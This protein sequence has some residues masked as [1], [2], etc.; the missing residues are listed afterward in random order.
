MLSYRKRGTNGLA[1]TG[2][3]RSDWWRH[4]IFRRELPL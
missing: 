1:V 3:R 2:L 4:R